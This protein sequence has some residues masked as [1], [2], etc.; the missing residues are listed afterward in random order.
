MLIL[1]LIIIR[2]EFRVLTM[3]IFSNFI[4]TYYNILYTHHA[5]I[6]EIN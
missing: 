4:T 2:S 6:K 5:V 1:N 3:E